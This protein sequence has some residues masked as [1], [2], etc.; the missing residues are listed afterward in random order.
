MANRVET[1]KLIDNNK[2]ALIKYVIFADGTAT[3]NSVLIRFGD[4]N[5]AIN[6][7]GYVSSVDP[8]VH[9]GVS[10]KR[11]YGVNK[12]QAAGAYISLKFYNDSNS[13]IV[14][15]GDGNFD[16]DIAG[17]AG[18]NAVI[19]SPVANSIGLVYSAVSPT[20]NDVFNLFIDMRKDS[21]DFDPGYTNDPTAFNKGWTI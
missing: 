18:E 14:A 19:N 12:V 3:A 13:E 15:L 6:A 10:I 20:N 8:Q 7:T 16:I 9:Y 17:V 5:N 21:S 4:L 1:H 2:R 11:I